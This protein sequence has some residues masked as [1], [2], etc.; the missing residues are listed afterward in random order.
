MTKYTSEDLAQ[1]A[2][3]IILHAGNARQIVQEAFNLSFENKSWEEINEKLIQARN[4]LTLAHKAQTNVI[5]DTIL[6]NNQIY[7]LL[8]SHAQDT[9]MTI[10]SELFI[11]ENMLKLHYSVYK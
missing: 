4:E 6:D 5:Q 2:M 8:F 10:N 7:S 11:A 9:L 3:K 1:I